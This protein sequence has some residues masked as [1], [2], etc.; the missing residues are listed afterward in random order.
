MHPANRLFWEYCTKHYPT[1]FTGDINVLEVGSHNING[2][3]RDHFHEV[4]RYIGV[5]WR[6]QKKY[7]DHVCF[8]HEMDFAEPFRTIISASMLEHDPHWYKSLCNMVKHMT[9]DGI[10]IL[11]WGSA[12]CQSHAPDHAP[13]HKF[14]ALPACNVITCLREQELLVYEF[15]YE[16]IHFGGD[17]GLVGLVAFKQAKSA[18]GR[19]NGDDYPLFDPLIKEDTEVVER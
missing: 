1:Y 18:E 19:V 6:G 5:D 16:K 14:H 11:S 3:L 4:K 2:S 15:I 10:M 7:V 12:L 8:A 13:D 9:D 17:E